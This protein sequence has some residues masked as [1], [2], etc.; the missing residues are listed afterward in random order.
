[1]T[2]SAVETYWQSGYVEQGMQLHAVRPT[3]NGYRAWCGAGSIVRLL[4]DRFVVSGTGFC[5]H[6]AEI[7][8]PPIPAQRAS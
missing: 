8:R 1:M 6:C 5:Q 4:T 2:A 7:L 3:I